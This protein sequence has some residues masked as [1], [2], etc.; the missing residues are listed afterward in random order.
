MPLRK[1]KGTGDSSGYQLAV[2]NG[3]IGSEQEWLSSLQGAKKVTAGSTAPP[4]PEIG[5]IWAKPIDN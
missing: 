5:D 1:A 3:F 4:D 2:N